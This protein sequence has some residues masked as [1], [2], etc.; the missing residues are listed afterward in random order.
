M[1]YIIPFIGKGTAE[2]FEREE[3]MKKFVTEARIYSSESIKILHVHKIVLDLQDDCR[4]ISDKTIGIE[5]C[6][7]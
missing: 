5:G 7:L 2:T 1:F 3:D 4:I 6:I